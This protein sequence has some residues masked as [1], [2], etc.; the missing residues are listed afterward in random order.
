[1]QFRASLAAAA[2]LLALA[3][4]RIVGIAVPET[5]R[6]GDDVDVVVETENYIQKVADIAIA[7][8]M[9]T[10]A[11]AFPTTLGQN[12]LGSFYLGPGADAPPT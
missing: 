10:N 7:F 1:M 4:A 6:A 12:D 2:S 3:N 11:S 5:V 9:A 8:G